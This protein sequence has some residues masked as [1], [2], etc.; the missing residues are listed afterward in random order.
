MFKQKTDLLLF[1]FQLFAVLAIFA[2]SVN[3]SPIL[4][5]YAVAH[6]PAVAV[7]A[8]PYNP[9][10]QYKFE[11]AISDPHTGD[12]KTQEET[13]DGDVVKGS[14]SLVEPDGSRRRVDYT[15]D[16]I[17][18]FNAIVKKEPLHHIT[19]VVS[20]AP[21]VAV[22]HAPLAIAHAPAPLTIA[23]APT[24]FTIAHAPAQLTYAHAPLTVAHGPTLSIN[25][26][27]Y[28]A[29]PVPLHAPITYAHAPLAY[30][31]A[32]ITYAHAPLAVKTGGISH[33]SQTVLH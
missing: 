5:P 27:P 2:V 32:P 23:H 15:A 10:P 33:H 21:A 25:H 16:S 17:N 31:Q 12:Q 1:L 28:L 7:K 14:Y 6:A 13:R 29:A 24:Q 30:A 11:Y 9:H 18:G 22:A 26:G 20:H 3:G 8:E 19:P 4:E